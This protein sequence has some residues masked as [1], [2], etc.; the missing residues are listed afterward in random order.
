MH[1]GK[2]LY[3]ADGFLEKVWFFV[4][5]FVPY[6]EGQKP[7]NETQ[8]GQPL[9]AWGKVGQFAEWQAYYASFHPNHASGCQVWKRAISISD[10]FQICMATGDN[11]YEEAEGYTYQGKA[12][13]APAVIGPCSEASCCSG[14]PPFREM[15]LT[16]TRVLLSRLPVTSTSQL[17]VTCK[18]QGC[19]LIDRED[20][21]ASHPPRPSVWCH[22]LISP[23]GRL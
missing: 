14:L 13:G 15:C 6:L 21:A 7:T 5:S 23:R 20:G 19:C 12:P 9:Y 3:D 2:A 1:S 18:G 17:A 8:N 10:E 4:D 11:E 16:P 22:A